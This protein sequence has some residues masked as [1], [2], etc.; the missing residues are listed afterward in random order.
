MRQYRGN[1][2]RL[3][4]IC[5]KAVRLEDCKVDEHGLAVHENCYVAKVLLEKRP[6]PYKTAS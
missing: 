2:P 6:I 5:G 1:S 3:C 4:W